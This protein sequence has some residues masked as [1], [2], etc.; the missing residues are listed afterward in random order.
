MLGVSLVYTVM[1]SKQGGGIH[2]DHAGQV[3]LSL[4][5]SPIVGFG[6]AALILLVWR[7]GGSLKGHDFSNLRIL[8]KVHLTGFGVY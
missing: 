3:F 2:W 5:I 4:L 6:A 1:H 8:K 7:C